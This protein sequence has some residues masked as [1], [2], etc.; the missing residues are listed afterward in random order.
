MPTCSPHTSSSQHAP[1]PTTTPHPPTTNALSPTSV[2]VAPD[3]IS[4]FNELKLGKDIKWIIFKISDNW[5]EIVVEE[6]SKTADYEVFREKL[7]SAKSKDKAGRDTIGPRYA[8]YDV[9]YD[10]GEGKRCVVSVWG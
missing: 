6:T 8:V 9:E 3:C 7:V 10:Q 5:K 1:S 4:T 2:S